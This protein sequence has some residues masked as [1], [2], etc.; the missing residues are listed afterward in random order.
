MPPLAL[1]PPEHLKRVLEADGFSVID[2][3]EFH[4]YLARGS[5]TIPI[6]L[7]K[8]A[9]EDGCVSMLVMEPLLREAGIDHY[10]YFALYKALFGGDGPEVN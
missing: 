8:E 3:D 2:E 9:G 6:H 10:K 5:R 4:W 1:I 7:P